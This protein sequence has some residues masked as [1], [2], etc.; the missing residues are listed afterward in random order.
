MIVWVDTHQYGPIVHGSIVSAP[1]SLTPGGHVISVSAWDTAGAE[2]SSLNYTITVQPASSSS[3]PLPSADPSP[4]PG[5]M[6]GPTVDIQSYGAVGD[7]V[8]DSTAAIVNASKAVAAAGGNLYIPSGTYMINP[9]EG[10]IVLGSN[11]MLYGSGTI[12]VMPDVGN[13]YYIIGP[14]DPGDPVSNIVI[15][16]ITIDENIFHNTS[17]SIIYTSSLSQVQDVIASYSLS[18]LTLENVTVYLS[19]V[20][21]ACISDNLTMNGNTIV[22]QRNPSNQWFDNSSVYMYKDKSTCSIS[23]NTWIGGAGSSVVPPDNG[24]ATYGYANTAIEVHGTARCTISDNTFDNYNTAV[25]GYDNLSLSVSGNTITRAINAI[26]LWSQNGFTNASIRDNNISL[27]N[28]D[29]G[30][31]IGTGINLYW[32]GGVNGDFSN[33]DIED[34]QVTFQPSNSPRLAESAFYGIGLHPNGN[35]NGATVKG[36]TITNAPLIGIQIGN[37]EQR[38]TVSNVVVQ[39]N[40]LIDAGNDFSQ[41]SV[42]AAISLGANLVNVNVSRNIIKGASNMFTGNYGVFA[43]PS[44]IYSGV[45]VYANSLS[46]G[47]VNLLPPT[48]S[49]AAP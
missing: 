2:G 43:L 30:S 29:K 3:P 33:I 7:G 39:N 47:Y 27:D 49:T 4:G 46:S 14:G 11:M 1:V 36:N 42:D 16:G 21:L 40:T 34:N 38:N 8:T 19:G 35:V 10:R 24:G 32:S 44:G 28:V 45:H 41:R 6:P 22:F 15:R 37:P 13:F 9:N 48:I 17:S 18:G 5:M 26:S 25:L 23:K 12:R 31:P 20:Y